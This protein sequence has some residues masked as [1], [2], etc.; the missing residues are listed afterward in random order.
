MCY[1]AFGVSS[2]SLGSDERGGLIR[3]DSELVLEEAA[4]QKLLCWWKEFH[5]I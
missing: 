4:Y 3:S 2:R 1:R 5:K